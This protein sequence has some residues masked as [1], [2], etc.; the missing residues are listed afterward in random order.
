MDSPAWAACATATYFDMR[1]TTIF[2]GVTEV[3]KNIISKAIL[4]L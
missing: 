1:K 3:Q 2:G 4:G